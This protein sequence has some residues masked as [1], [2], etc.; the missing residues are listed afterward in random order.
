MN[1][2]MNKYAYKY[3]YICICGSLIIGKFES[4]FQFGK[5]GCYARF[6]VLSCLFQYENTCHFTSQ[7]CT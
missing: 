7:L 3:T 6:V 5:I 2:Y 4:L 1:A